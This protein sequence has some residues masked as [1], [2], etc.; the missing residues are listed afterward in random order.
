MVARL[1][2]FCSECE[3]GCSE[4]SP[5]G[6]DLLKSRFWLYLGVA[7]AVL[8]SGCE[9]SSPKP[10]TLSSVT[11]T[12]VDV[13][14][15]GR[16]SGSPVTES[17]HYLRTSGDVLVGCSSPNLVYLT[18]PPGCQVTF[19]LLGPNGESIGEFRVEGL[20]IDD[21]A[22]FASPCEASEGFLASGVTVTGVWIDPGTFRAH[23]IDSVPEP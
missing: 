19:A 15:E 20:E 14:E 2:L 10:I 22:E 13:R 18:C 12:K 3:C 8:M 4:G 11:S 21:L 23:S 16:W 6:E 17:L 5:T 1:D 9:S 7:S